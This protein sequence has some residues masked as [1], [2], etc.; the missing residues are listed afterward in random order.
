MNK[1]AI[2]FYS[3]TGNTRKMV[4]AFEKSAKDAGSAVNTYRVTDSVDVDDV[5]S[6]DVIVLACSACGSE[7]IEEHFFVPFMEN[8]A[9]KFKDKKV[10]IFGSYGWGGGM[11]ADSWR[12]QIEGFGAKIVAM[13]I[14][15]N[16]D[17]SDEELE[18]LRATAV[19]L[20]TI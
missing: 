14:L 19:K 12:E 8:N 15:A 10:Y 3:A 4:E 9:A 1:M 18:Q 5:F 7:V 16:E 6:S 11:F 20:T 17:A 2:V 13:P